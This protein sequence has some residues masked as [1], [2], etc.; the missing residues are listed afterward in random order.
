MKNNI[1]EITHL[2]KNYQDKSGEIEAINDINLSV[3]EGEFIVIV[4]PS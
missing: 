3:N 4:G 1:L 2:S